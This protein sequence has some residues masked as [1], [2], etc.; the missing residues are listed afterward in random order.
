[1]PPAVF[2]VFWSIFCYTKNRKGAWALNPLNIFLEQMDWG[3]LTN[4]LLSIAAVLLCLTVHE[5]SHGFAAYVM[6]D[7][8]AKAHHRISLNPL[9]HVDFLGLMMMVMVGFGWA[10]PVPVDRR[11]FRNPR[12]GMMVTALAGPLS[13]FALAYLSVLIYSAVFP[14]YQLG[15]LWAGGICEFFFTV[16]LMSIG[17]GLF[18]LIPV[19]PL[20]G[21]KILEGVFGDKIKFNPQFSRCGGIILLALL[22]SGVLQTPL[23]ALRNLI[24]NGMI[25]GA[26]WIYR[27]SWM[28][29]GF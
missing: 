28:F 6:G 5:A 27:L 22:W 16:A 1:M 18:N 19:P 12:S 20:D 10:K 14:F 23:V 9:R 21:S 2:L 15:N 17:L 26:D 29:C 7:P 25:H 24:F 11:Y 4:F 3:G 13:N 8:T